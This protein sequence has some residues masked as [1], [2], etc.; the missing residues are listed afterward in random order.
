MLPGILLVGPGANGHAPAQT[1]PPH[2]H[3]VISAAHTASFHTI[4]GDRHVLSHAF[5]P[6]FD[7]GARHH[8]CPQS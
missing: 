2:Q 6:H 3:R 8:C 5:Q 4:A 1:P 7:E